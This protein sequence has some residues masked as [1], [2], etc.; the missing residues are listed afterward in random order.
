M[1]QQTDMCT[2]M[3]HIYVCIFICIHTCICVHVCIHTYLP[4]NKKYTKTEGE[5]NVNKFWINFSFFFF[6]FNNRVWFSFQDVI[7]FKNCCGNSEGSQNHYGWKRPLRSPSPTL[8]PCTLTISLSATSPLFLNTS[9]TTSLGSLC[10]CLTTLSEKICFLISNLNLP[11]HN[12]RPLPL[13]LLMLMDATIWSC[14]T[15]YCERES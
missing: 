3:E 13:I 4:L 7:C 14:I 2:H 15:L 5:Q 12:L 6:F 11:L 1:I 10:Q 9:T 8:S